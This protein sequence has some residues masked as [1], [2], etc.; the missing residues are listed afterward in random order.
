M[1]Y[2]SYSYLLIFLGTVFISYTAA[3]KKIKW[4]VL[5][6]ASYVFYALNSG[7]LT[8]FLLLSTAAVYFA[9]ILLDCIADTS[10][11]AKKGLEREEKKK[12]KTLINYQKKAIVVLTLGF[13]FGILLTIKYSGF[14]AGIFNRAAE[15]VRLDFALPEFKFLMP[16]GISY[17]TLQAAGYVIDVYRGKYRA[18]RNFGKVA[19]FLSF[20]P[21]ITEGPI[22]RFDELADPLYEGHGFSYD[23]LTKGLQLMAWGLFKKMVIADRVNIFVSEVFGN[24]GGCSGSKIFSLNIGSKYIGVVSSY[25]KSHKPAVLLSVVN[26]SSSCFSIKRIGVSFIQKKGIF[27]RLHGLRMEGKGFVTEADQKFGLFQRRNFQGGF[28]PVF[29]LTAGKILIAII[30]S[31]QDFLKR[32]NSCTVVQF[33][34]IPVHRIFQ[35]RGKILIPIPGF[36]GLGCTIPGQ[37]RTFRRN[38]SLIQSSQSAVD[39]IGGIRGNT[40]DCHVLVINIK[41]ILIFVI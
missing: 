35:G 40:P 36:E 5:L 4:A 25:G 24:Y 26:D 37:M 19:L 8:V 27:H 17:Y 21:Q 14:F 16:L 15:F 9:G 34:K 32:Q 10:A 7:K 30:D 13:I 18:S 29:S 12:L 39:F 38:N 2:T 3:P 33:T 22:G 1:S 31:R 23:N 20:F 28:Q 6:T 41:L 11:L